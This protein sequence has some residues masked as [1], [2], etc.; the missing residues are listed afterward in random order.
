MAR[1]GR[2]RGFDRDE[3]LQQATHAFWRDGYESTSLAELKASMGDISSP[4]FYAAFGSKE[5]LFSE[6]L[7]HWI[8]TH[9]QALTPLADKSLAPRQAI[10]QALR[11]S[12]AMQTDASHPPGCLLVLSTSTCPPKSAALREQ[13]M[14][15]RKRTQAGLLACV[16][17]AVARGDLPD[18]VKPKALATT[19]DTFLQGMTV[20]AREGATLAV[21]EASISQMLMLWDTLASARA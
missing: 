6:V 21:L 14:A 12:A 2:P 10:D 16:R 1:T 13:L 4:S 5:A 9:G 8:G 11:R 15:E 3:A 17:R 20:M 7:E 18:S 19:F